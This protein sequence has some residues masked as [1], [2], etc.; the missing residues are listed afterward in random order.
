MFLKT[1]KSLIPVNINTLLIYI[2]LLP[3]LTFCAIV[4]IHSAFLYVI[5]Q[6]Y[7]LEI[8]LYVVSCLLKMVKERRSC[9]YR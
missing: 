6:K 3:L 4:V 8:L 1:F 2:I 9:V 5:N 7:T